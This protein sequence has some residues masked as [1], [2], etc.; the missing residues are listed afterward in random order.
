[1]LPQA[2]LLPQIQLSGRVEAMTSEQ[3]DLVRYLSSTETSKPTLQE[4]FLRSLA[5]RANTR[6]ELIEVLDACIEAE[7]RLRFA[8]WR[9]EELRLK[10][11]EE[12]RTLNV[13]CA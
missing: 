5:E 4:F 11:A 6:K 2:A 9:L 1:M 3:R 10:A 13:E 7:A 8:E 12:E